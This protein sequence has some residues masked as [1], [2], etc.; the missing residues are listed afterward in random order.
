MLA[1]CSFAGEK[2]R[3]VTVEGKE[4]TQIQDAHI[5]SD[6]RV[7]LLVPGGG[8]TVTA[9]QLPKE[10][11]ESWNITD[12]ALAKAKAVHSHTTEN[13]FNQ[14][15]RAGLFR[16]VDGIVYDMRKPQPGWTHFVNAQVLQV[17]PD[18]ALLDM[19]SNPRDI[20]AVMVKHLPNTISDTDKIT[21]FAKLTGNFTYLNRSG[22]DRTIRSYDAGRICAKDEIP[23]EI[24]KQGRASGRLQYAS[25]PKDQDT[26]ALLPDRRQLRAIGS[27]FFVTADGYLLTNFHVVEN[28]DHIKIKYQDGFTTAEVVKVDRHNDVALLK[29]AGKIFSPLLFPTNTTVSLGEAVFT[30][31]F[32]NIDL[33][34][35]E[36][37]Y[38]D[39]RI[40]SLAGLRDDPTEYQISVPVQPGNSGGP[41]CNAKGEVIGLVVARLNDMAMLRTSGAIPQNVNYAVKAQY[42][43]ELLKK[44]PAINLSLQKS[45]GKSDQSIT[46]VRD[47]IAMVLIY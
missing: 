39:G 32:P 13:L 18:G 20:V 27:G 22:G 14:A 9:E 30:I 10:F 8:T 41:L 24:V 46:T 4:I 16:E 29:V 3:R 23:E 25:I 40:S 12:E 47:S 6:G 33:Q 17:V 44:V 45:T 7:V 34:G 36:P 26:T 21:V 42:A 31:G 35:L 5:V 28:A 15:V 19:T 2:L 11:L 1:F 37:K 38:T 43:L